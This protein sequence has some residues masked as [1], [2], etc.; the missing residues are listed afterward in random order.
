LCPREI[1]FS[2][3]AKKKRWRRRSGGG[4]RMRHRVYAPV[5]W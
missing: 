5:W 1:K 3:N 4:W 2:S